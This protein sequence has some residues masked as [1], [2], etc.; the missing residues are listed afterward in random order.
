MKGGESKAEATSTDQRLKTRGRK[1]GKKTKKDPNQPKRPPSAFFVFLEDFR[2]EFNLA[3][4]NNK[5]VA[6]VGKAAGA[7]WKSMTEEDKAPYVAKAESRKTEYLKT[8]QQYN[9]K[10]ANG[11]SRGEEDDSD[12]SKSEVDE[13][14]SEEEEEDDD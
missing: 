1:P 3:N 10:L 12:K 8:M 13:A 4:P 14:G 2:K 7:R 5:S 9:M 11:T 6:T